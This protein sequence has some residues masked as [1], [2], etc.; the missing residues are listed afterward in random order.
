M[1]TT[2]WVMACRVLFPASVSDLAPTSDNPSSPTTTIPPSTPKAPISPSSIPYPGNSKV[3]S[4][5]VTN[6]NPETNHA[7]IYLGSSSP[8]LPHRFFRF[9]PVPVRDELHR[10]PLRTTPNI[11]L[12]LYLNYTHPVEVQAV[13]CDHAELVEAFENEQPPSQPPLGD[14]DAYNRGLVR[15]EQ[16]DLERFLTA[17]R[18]YKASHRDGRAVA[19]NDGGGNGS[20]GGA[21]GGGN[22]QLSWTQLVA[23][24]PGAS[25]DAL[26]VKMFGNAEPPSSPNVGLAFTENGGDLVEVP[27]IP[28]LILEPW[29]KKV[30][31]AT[32]ET[33]GLDEVREFSEEAAL[34]TSAWIN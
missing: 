19:T 4:C 29:T 32:H 27:L 28:T 20:A 5:L 9:G 14:L 24:N 13:F 2:A 11:D 26:L 18:E 25:A 10:Q 16:P 31:E 22:A 17:A 34:N 12:S 33:H 15:L 8:N 23:D 30:L 6:F 7:T 1:S 3:R 21:S